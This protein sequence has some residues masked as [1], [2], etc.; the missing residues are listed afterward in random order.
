MLWPRE[1]QGFISCW[2]LNFEMCKSLLG[3]PDFEGM[4]GLGE[5]LRLGTVR[6]G[7][8]I[9]EGTASEA[10]EGPKG[11]HRGEAGH[12]EE[13]TGDTVGESAA[14]WSGDLSILERSISWDDHQEE[15]NGLWPV[16]A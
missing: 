2:Q 12:R 11:P 4:Q 14:Q 10:V 9:G 1:Y 7:K 8:A 6:P 16:G 13:S 3:A 15:L 5:Q